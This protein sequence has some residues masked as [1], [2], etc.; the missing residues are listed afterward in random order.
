MSYRYRILWSLELVFIALFLLV[1]VLPIQDYAMREYKEYM[2]SPSAE[3][4]KAFEDKRQEELQV[5]RDGAILIAIAVSVL[6]ILLYRNRP[7][8]PVS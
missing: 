1:L 7:K 3:T 8:S 4:R 6:T 2:Q 5:R